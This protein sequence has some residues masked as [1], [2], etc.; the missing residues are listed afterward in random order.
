MRFVVSE[1]EKKR[2]KK[3][4]HIQE[5][6]W[7]M[8][9]FNMLDGDSGGDSGGGSGGG[10]VYGKKFSKSEGEIKHN[11]T[12]KAA[13]NIK[14][15]IDKMKSVGINKASEQVG[16]LAVIGSESKFIPKEEESYSNTSNSRIRDI[17][18]TKTSKLPTNDLNTLK[19][20]SKKFFN[21][22]Y[23]DVNGNEGGDDG[24][25]FRGR[26]FNQLTGRAN[27]RKYGYENNPN[28]LNNVTDA[29][30]VAIE[31]LTNN[32]PKNFDDPNEAAQY[33]LNKNAGGSPARFAQTA[34]S[35]ELRNFDII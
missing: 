10:S 18:K 27:Y 21:F 1:S 24:Y 29:A 26:G 16:I 34:V 2:I 33:Y 25:D 11:Y 9:F 31:F 20:D 14:T 8:H 6:S 12:G 15:L 3:L 28:A 5:Q 23:S 4:Y 35:K 7:L 13:E 22:V 30:K 17:F 32:S 19:N